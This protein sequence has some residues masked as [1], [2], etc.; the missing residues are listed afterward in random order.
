MLHPLTI[1]FPINFFNPEK[2]GMTRAQ[3]DNNPDRFANNVAES[4]GKIFQK[5][6][7][8]AR[9]A[10]TQSDVTVTTELPVN[11]ASIDFTIDLLKQGDY[12]F[13][14]PIME[15]MLRV[16]PD[17]KA[18]LYN[19]GLTLSDQER[20]GDAVAILRRLTELEPEN[21]FGWTALGVALGRMGDQ[22]GAVA[23]LRKALEA[24]PNDGYAHRNLGS[25]LA[26]TDIN[27]ALKHFRIALEM[28]PDDQVALYNY[29]QALKVSGDIA[30][31]HI[32]LKRA[33]EIDPQSGIAE[34]CEKLLTAIAQA[35]MRKTVGGTLRMDVVMYC[36][37]ALKLFTNDRDL[38]KKV[39]FEIALLGQ[40]G[41]DINNP[42]KKY[43]LKNLEGEFTGM[44]LVS[45]MYV[46][47]SILM[48]GQDAG[49]DLSPEFKAAKVLF[50][51]K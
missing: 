21:A 3:A 24:D 36:L 9:I 37:S 16:D 19:L 34:K 42:D 29:G 8:N 14:T 44:H 38:C 26:N 40:H 43:K 41:L 7:Q 31:A 35:V 11:D 12:H 33:I 20:F 5:I 1:K 15:A 2:F 18:L 49:I 10:V 45:Y 28:L 22:T 50:E 17:N 25:M 23:A 6:G 51:G 27:E 32:I 4:L 48:P 39:T 47:T 46:G 13:A 30:E